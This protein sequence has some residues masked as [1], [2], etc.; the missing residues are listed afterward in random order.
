MF[1]A[2]LRGKVATGAAGGASFRAGLRRR[3]PGGTGDK[4]LGTGED[5]FAATE[6]D[7]LGL[8]CTE[9]GAPVTHS[10]VVLNSISAPCPA[11]TNLDTALGKTT[12]DECFE[13]T[14]LIDSDVCFYP[15][16]QDT[17]V[18]LLKTAD[19]PHRRITVD[20]DK[21]HDSFLLEPRLFT[22]H[23]TDTLTNP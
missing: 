14:L 2:V 8:D 12:N 4:T 5:T 15:D 22:P 10:A 19:V 6:G 3:W 17:L 21:G 13:A 18:R 20:S 7:A 1:V 11:P 23:I 9:T 16:E